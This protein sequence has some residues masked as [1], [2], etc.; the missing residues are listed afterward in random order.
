MLDSSNRILVS[1]LAA[2]PLLALAGGAAA[3]TPKEEAKRHFDAGNALLENED[4]RAAAAEFETSLSLYPT[5]M[6]LFNVAN[7][8]KVMRRYGDAL[9]AIARIRSEFAGKIGD[10]EPE[11]AAFEKSVL[12]IVGKLEVRVDRDGAAVA[13]DGVDVARSPLKKPLVLAPGDHTVRVRLS[14]QTDQQRKVRI[15]AGEQRVEEFDFTSDKA[16]PQ[17]PPAATGEIPT[18]VEPDPAS[19]PPKEIEPKGRAKL[20]PLFWSGVAATAVAGILSGVFYGVSSGA[21]K[22]LD[23][24][25]SDYAEVSASLLASPDDAALADE[26]A[27]LWGQ[28]EDASA[29]TEKFGNLGA[30][31]LVASGVLV[32]AT[33]V[34][35]IVSAKKAPRETPQDTPAVSVGAGGI[36]ASF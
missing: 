18:A 16:G 7:C 9:D 13:V 19:P 14:G 32:G 29:R 25:K 6:G 24:Y 15:V 22:D 26:E 3:Q 2:L 20:G 34:V 11:V 23:G 36:V 28:M 33:V 12:A 35:A 21:S 10:L 1:V 8:Y 27:K 5:K 17:A 31:F 30:G 4:Y